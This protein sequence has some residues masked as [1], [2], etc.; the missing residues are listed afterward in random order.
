MVLIDKFRQRRV[1]ASGQIYSAIRVPEKPH[2]V[3]FHPLKSFP[4]YPVMH[5]I[6]FPVSHYQIGIPEYPEVLRHRCR[7]DAEGFGKGIHAKRAVFQ[8]FDH[9]HPCFNRKSL[10]K[11][12]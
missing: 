3:V 2:G 6:P 1:T 4:V 9:F 5:K 12:C 10:E 11:P 7:S 8:Q